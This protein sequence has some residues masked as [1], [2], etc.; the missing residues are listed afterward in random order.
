MKRGRRYEAIRKAQEELTQAS[1]GWQRTLETLTP[2]VTAATMAALN[3]GLSQDKVALALGITEI[4]V[5]AVDRQMKL[6]LATMAV[7]EPALGTLDQWIG[8]AG[9]QFKVAA[10]TG[11]QFKTMLEL[12]GGTVDTLVPKIEK[13]DMT[14]RSVTE[15]AK[16]AGVTPGMDQKAPGASVPVDLGNISFGSLGYAR[17]FEEYTKKADAGGGM[18]GG[19][20]GGGPPKD[21]LTWALSMGLALPRADGDE[22]VQHRRHRKRDR[23]ARR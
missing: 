1:G 2:T 9:Q 6:N 16:V 3:Y 12:T 19:A 13:L 15:A 8:S 22:H 11:D 10:E 18:L 23:P 5:A 17:V 14:F 20:I 21:F 7:T 4:Q